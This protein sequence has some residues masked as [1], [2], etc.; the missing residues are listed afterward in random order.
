MTV[1]CISGF[2]GCASRAAVIPAR[3]ATAVT[4]VQQPRLP[5]YPRFPGCLVEAAAEGRHE[6][7]E[8]RGALNM[9]RTL[10][11]GKRCSILVH[12]EAQES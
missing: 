1:L 4:A 5:L 9:K 6:V 7:T 8:F 11:Y 3:H 10:E 12:C 2:P